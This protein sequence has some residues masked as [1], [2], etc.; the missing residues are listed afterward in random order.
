MNVLLLK[1][2]TSEIIFSRT[3]FV[4]AAT[5]L[6][7]MLGSYQGWYSFPET[8]GLFFVFLGLRGY[9]QSQQRGAGTR[10]VFTQCGQR[11]GAAGF[12]TFGV[13]ATISTAIGFLVGTGSFPIIAILA[14]TACLGVLALLAGRGRIGELEVDGE[15]VHSGI[16]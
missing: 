1:R 8:L 9:H 7:F 5:G 13:G 6:L 2:L 15:A 4:Q 3:L 11:L 14:V 12:L 16:G 10:A